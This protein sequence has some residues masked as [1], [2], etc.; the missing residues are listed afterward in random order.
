MDP[1]F[2]DLNP[3]EGDGPL[4]AIKT[5][6]TPS[7]GAEVKP[8]AQCRKILHVKKFYEYVTYIS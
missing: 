8:L 3:A 1:R 2:V 7:F 4:R 6:S 5:R